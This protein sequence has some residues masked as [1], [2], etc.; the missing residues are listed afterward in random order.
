M[1][2]N[3]LHVYGIETELSN[4]LHHKKIYTMASVNKHLCRYGVGYDITDYVTQQFDY[5]FSDNFM[6]KIIDADTSDMLETD[7]TCYPVTVFIGFILDELYSD[8]IYNTGMPPYAEPCGLYPISDFD[9][10]SNQQQLRH[11]LTVLN[12]KKTYDLPN[13]HHIM[14]EFVNPDANNKSDSSDDQ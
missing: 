14:I 7:K 9:C 6:V 12:D 10:E 1:S 13:N 5:E 11:I 4:I 2:V 8:E 3:I